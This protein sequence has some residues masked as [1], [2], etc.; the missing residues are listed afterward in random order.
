[1]ARA[2]TRLPSALRPLFPWLKTGVLRATQAVSPL[3]RR[4]PG[5][6]P[7]TPRGGVRS[8]VRRGPIPLVAWRSR[9]WSPRWISTDRFRRG[10]PPTTRNSRRTV[11]LHPLSWRHYG[12]GRVL[13]PYAAVMTEDDTLL[14]DLSPYY[15]AAV[16][17]QHPVFLRCRPP[18]VT[19]RPG[20]GR[21]AHDTGE[22]ELLPLPY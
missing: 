4:L 16:P 9:R 15:G 21:R 14:F 11:T 10:C 8:R 13:A 3:T 20:V 12:S 17:S 6:T 1:M 5:A 18:V 22:R 19:E 2:V 7:T